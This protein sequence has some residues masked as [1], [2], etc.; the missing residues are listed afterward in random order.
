MLTYRAL[1]DGARACADQL[2]EACPNGGHVVLPM[3]TDP[4]SVMTLLGCLYAGI[5]CAPVSVPTGGAGMN[6][7]R[8]LADDPHCTVVVTTPADLSKLVASVGKKVV[9]IDDR[10]TVARTCL[11]RGSDESLA[12]IQFTSGSIS[13]PKGVMLT[14]ASIAANLEMLRGAFA[15]GPHDSFASWLPLF[16]DMGLAMLLMPLYFGRPGV[17]MPPTSFIRDPARWLGV[18]AADRITITG[19]PNFAYEL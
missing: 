5:A 3:R 13:D 18:I 6:R 16:H 14:H 12:L 19:A 10:S 4:Q 17:L 1:D 8:A 9:V 2:M 11:P 7:L 15:V